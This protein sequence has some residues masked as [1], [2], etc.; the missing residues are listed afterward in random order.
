MTPQRGRA[1]HLESVRCTGTSALAVPRRSRARRKKRSGT[2]WF[3]AHGADGGDEFSDQLEVHVL[4]LAKLGN[5]ELTNEEPALV[6]WGKF[7]SA[8]SDERLEELAMKDP[9]LRQAKDALDRLSA[10]PNARVLAEMRD[11]AQKSYQLDLAKSRKEGKAEGKAEGRA[12]GRAEGYSD[13]VLQQLAIKFG[14]LPLSVAQR[15]QAATMTELQVWGTKVLT[16]NTLESVFEP[17]P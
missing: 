4:E 17:S 16:A 8:T 7:L 5:A 2:Q 15:V 9:M 11:M 1:R 10:D 3:E 6:T 14:P 12:E 13:L